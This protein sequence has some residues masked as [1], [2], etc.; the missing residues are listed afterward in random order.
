MDNPNRIRVLDRFKSHLRI[1][2]AFN[3]D[4]F[5]ECNWR[6]NLRS[7]GYAFCA[8]VIILIIPIM[9]V[10]AIW[11][12]VENGADFNKVV[13]AL[14]VVCLLQRTQS[15]FIAL[16]LKNRAINELINRLQRCVEQRELTFYYLAISFNYLI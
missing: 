8:T 14:P 13:V 5:R 15:T 2:E 9:N 1:L 12:S 4:H 3:A 16:I 11:N 10:L 6:T 7:I